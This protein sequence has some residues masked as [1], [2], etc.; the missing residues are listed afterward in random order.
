VVVKNLSTDERGW[1]RIFFGNI[2]NDVVFVLNMGNSI[3]RDDIEYAIHSDRSGNIIGP[4]SK[5]HAH[6]DGA[7]PAL[8]HYST[9]AMIYNPKLKKYGLQLKRPKAHDKFSKPKRDMGVAGHNCYFKEDGIYRPLLFGENLAKETDEEIGLKVKMCEDADE[10]MEKAKNLDGTIGFIFEEFLFENEINSEWVGAGLILTT[11][12]ELEF[13]DDEV[14]EFKWLSLDELDE[15]LK[16][17]DS[18]YGALPIIYEKAEK[19][20]LENF[21]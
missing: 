17:E 7:R 15:F 13:K 18:Y 16:D 14:I 10:F 1:P 21:G 12:S 2:Y 5:A 8:T 4:I 19:F 11:E 20:R 3:L 6:L 9:W